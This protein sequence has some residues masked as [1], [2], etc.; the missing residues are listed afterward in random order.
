M[1][2]GLMYMDRGEGTDHFAYSHA[3]VMA[4]EVELI[5][6]LSAMNT[7]LDKFK[8]LPCEVKT[9][10][11]T[12]GQKALVRAILTRRDPTGVSDEINRDAPD[13]VLDTHGSWWSPVIERQLR[14][15]I[16][17]AEIVH[18]VVQHPGLAG[19]MT[20]AYRRLFPPRAHILIAISDYGFSELVRRYPQ[21]VHV[22]SRHGIFLP[23]VQPDTQA[24]ATRRHKMLFFGRIDRYKGI[25]FL[26]EA[27]GIAKKSNPDLH[28]DIMG[29]GYIA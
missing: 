12:R 2:L 1:R 11:W 20:A 6:Y 23:D 26:V 10:D 8:A 7:L 29:G 15:D 3:S 21:K 18:D 17:I 4:H 13:I 5:C 16:T 24:I 19:V 22:A 25:E 9:F 14:P 27:Y 28:L